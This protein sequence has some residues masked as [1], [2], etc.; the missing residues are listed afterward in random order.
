MSVAKMEDEAD[1]TAIAHLMNGKS[2]QK[3][4]DRLVHNDKYLN[5][6]I[7]AVFYRSECKK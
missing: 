2:T 4:D 1:L 6:D 7:K 3:D 5:G